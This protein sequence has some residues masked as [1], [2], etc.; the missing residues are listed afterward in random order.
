MDEASCVT[1]NRGSGVGCR[2]LS[3][4]ESDQPSTSG[5]VPTARPLDGTNMT[6]I[7]IC[8]K[9]RQF[10]HMDCRTENKVC[11]QCAEPAAR[12]LERSSTRYE[13]MSIQST[14]ENYFH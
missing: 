3:P 4:F 11:L 7:R 8:L 14:N 12:T 5:D 13:T 6:D 1:H 10:S 2:V 9:C